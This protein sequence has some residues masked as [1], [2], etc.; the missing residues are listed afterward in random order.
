MEPIIQE[1]HTPV[2]ERDVTLVK[3]IV[4]DAIETGIP[5]SGNFERRI[6]FGNV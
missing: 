3:A 6:G 1:I 2:M 4:R 5:V